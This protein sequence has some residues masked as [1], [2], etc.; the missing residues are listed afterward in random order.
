MLTKDVRTKRPSPTV[1]LRQMAQ[2]AHDLRA[3]LVDDP[4]ADAIAQAATCAAPIL[5]T[6]PIDS[7]AA[8]HWLYPQLEPWEQSALDQAHDSPPLPISLSP[9]LA[10][11]H[12]YDS[13][14]H[15]YARTSKK[16]RGVFFTLAAICCS[17]SGV[18]GALVQHT[19]RTPGSTCF[20][21]SRR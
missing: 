9:P 13:F 6:A 16:H 5:A 1:I 3:K 8:L 19:S 2:R 21:A 15:H 14:L 12:L 10:P 7:A 11:T 20:I 4:H 17:I 18:S